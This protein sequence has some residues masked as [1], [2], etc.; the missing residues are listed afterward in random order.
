VV[1]EVSSKIKVVNS[2]WNGPGVIKRKVA[3]YYVAEGRAVFVSERQIRLV[4]S[5]PKN[6]AAAARA[7]TWARK[8]NP[9]AR[10]HT[11]EIKFERPERRPTASRFFPD[12]REPKAL[13]GKSLPHETAKP[14]RAALTRQNVMT[15]DDKNTKQWHAYGTE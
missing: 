3:E 5:H 4:E 9:P 6:Q 7:G 2:V 1:V 10:E 15:I 14:P 8:H 13:L 11:R 12:G